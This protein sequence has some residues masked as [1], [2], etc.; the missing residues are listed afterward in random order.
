MTAANVNAI[1]YLAGTG[2]QKAASALVGGACGLLTAGGR[3]KKTKMDDL[4]V[5]P[6][7]E[8]SIYV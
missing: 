2:A 1:L 4:E 6:F 5:A 7:Q 8:T 3:A